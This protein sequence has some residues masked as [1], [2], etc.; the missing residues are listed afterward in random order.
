MPPKTIQFKTRVVGEKK[1][2]TS[3]K[4]TIELSRE[5]NKQIHI[6]DIRKMYNDFEQKEPNSKFIITALTVT[7]WKTLKSMD[8]EFITEEEIEDYFR[9]YVKNDSKFMTAEK[10]TITRFS[11]NK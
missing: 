9:G 8:D 4:K 2:K 1:F 5:D 7:G 3:S 11:I 10:F 6:N